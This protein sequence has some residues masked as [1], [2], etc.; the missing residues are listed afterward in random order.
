MPQASSYWGFGVVDCCWNC[1][2]GWTITSNGPTKQTLATSNRVLS[3][4][5]RLLVIVLH[6]LGEFPQDSS[7]SRPKL[8]H[9]SSLILTAISAG[10]KSTF[11]VHPPPF[12]SLIPAFC[13]SISRSVETARKK[14]QEDHFLTSKTKLID[15]KISRSGNRAKKTALLHWL[16]FL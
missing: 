8:S 13:V 3:I 6:P 10:K 11:K 16:L 4:N 5:K 14:G 12:S 7:I 2:N 15:S 9:K 1:R